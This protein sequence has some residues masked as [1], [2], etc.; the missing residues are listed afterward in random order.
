MN[1]LF[2]GIAAA[3]FVLMAGCSSKVENPDLG[4]VLDVFIDSLNNFEASGTEQEASSET[5]QAF[6]DQTHQMLNNPPIMSNP[7]GLN[8]REDGSFLGFNDA[9]QNN[10]QDAGEQD[11]F[12][13]E[14]DI[15]RS[16]LIATDTS[17]T[18]TDMRFSG[19]GFLAGAIIGNLLGRQRASGI[20]ANS[21]AS[22]N[23]TPRSSYS[24]ARAKSFS[25]SHSFGK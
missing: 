13:V 16:R 10:I 22:R 19:M 15:E 7:V 6:T 3:S 18:A 23:V 9:N 17:G 21:F 20:S 24:S 1:K 4:K 5:M 8:L 2:A 14:I 25:G 12:T 11:L